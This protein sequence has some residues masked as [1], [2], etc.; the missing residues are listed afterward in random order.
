MPGHS[1]K[2]AKRQRGVNPYLHL[3][4]IGGDADQLYIPNDHST[5]GMAGI[6][7][8][9]IFAHYVTGS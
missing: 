5:A 9:G 1:R 8:N 4:H 2:H 7:E 6:F 3:E